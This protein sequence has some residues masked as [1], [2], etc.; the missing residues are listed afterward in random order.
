[1]HQRRA[2]AS[3]VARDASRRGAPGAPRPLLELARAYG[4]DSRAAEQVVGDAVAAAE[5]EPWTT[6]E[7]AARR[8]LLFALRQDPRAV[9]PAPGSPARLD[10]ATDLV[11]G[12][13]WQDRWAGL[14]EK[15]RTAFAAALLDG[16]DMTALA[17]AQRTHRLEIKAR[18]RRAL[19][20]LVADG[21][22]GSGLA[23]VRRMA[24]AEYALGI[25]TTD[26]VGPFRRGLELDLELQELVAAWDARLAVLL[27]PA[28]AH[29]PAP[30]HVAAP[31]RAD[32]AVRR[33]VAATL[34]AVA[35]PCAV[36]L[37]VVTMPLG[38]V[39]RAIVSAF[40]PA[41]PMT[42]PAPRR[43][44]A[45]D[46]DLAAAERAAA[47]S[48]S[49]LAPTPVVELAAAAMPARR[50]PPVAQPVTTQ[51]G[52]DDADTPA[53]ADAA[54]VLS[55]FLHHR[56][57]DPELAARA[58]DLAERLRAAGLEVALVDT[59]GLVVSA[60]RLRFFFAADAAATQTLSARLPLPVQVQDFTHYAPRPTPGTVEFWLSTTPTAG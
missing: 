5:A 23:A 46:M 54:S 40:A 26:A 39:E 15:E 4:L 50:A 41:E 53:P 19:S 8:A 16:L 36:A 2:P 57:D 6:V 31:S 44:A 51:L 59:G 60:N 22:L 56:A 35:A 29:D 20:R 34:L 52:A 18:V 33:P 13:E 21:A 28:D 14:T 37:G 47:A 43:A 49:S 1:M 25:V 17:L 11:E 45:A 30:M 42:L 27:P 55:V 32:R 58:A 3:A 7:A 12:G 10:D 9:P 38:M 48:S 24:A